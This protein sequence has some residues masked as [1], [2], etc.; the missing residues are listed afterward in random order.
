MY[1]NNQP[2]SEQYLLTRPLFSYYT[3]K[4]TSTL[5]MHTPRGKM[6]GFNDEN[7]AVTKKNC[8]DTKALKVK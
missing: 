8:Y 2:K 4:F 5:S 1:I 7:F 3:H 6:F